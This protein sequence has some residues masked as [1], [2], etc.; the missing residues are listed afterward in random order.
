DLVENSAEVGDIV[1]SEEVGGA[2]LVLRR[3]MFDRVYLGPHARRE[4]ERARATL[5]RIFD[6]LVE[7]GDEADAI[8][9]FVSGMTDRFALEYAAR[10]A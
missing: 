7:R 2:M 8:V 9:S 3:F 1:Q 5:R 6:S 4:H 10:L